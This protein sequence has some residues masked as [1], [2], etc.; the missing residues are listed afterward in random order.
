[1]KKYRMGWRNNY[2]ENMPWTECI[3]KDIQSAIRDFFVWLK[4]GFK[5]PII[6]VYPDYPSKKTTIYKIAKSLNY[7]LTNKPLGRAE[8]VIYF[9]DVTSASPILPNS[10]TSDRM[11]VNLNCTDISKVKVDAVH[12]KVFGYNTFIDPSSYVGK[13]VQKSDIN[14]LHD[15]RIIQCPIHQERDKASVFQVLIDNTSDEQH[16]MDFRVPVYGNE[17]PLVYRKYKSLDK[18]FTNDVNWSELETEVNQIFTQ[19]EIDQILAFTRSMNVEFCELDILRNKTDGLIYIIDV[20]KTPYGPP[21]GLKQVEKEKAVQILASAFD[22][23]IL[24][25]FGLSVQ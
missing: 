23:N 10:L 7:R 9:D 12:M 4:G 17:I 24:R 14:A 11:V 18:R 6:V 3:A 5:L 20:N 16:V 22:K 8:L 21:S 13:A 15:G 19:E 1:M 25:K 2:R